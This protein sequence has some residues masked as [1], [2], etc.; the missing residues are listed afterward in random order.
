MFE[1]LFSAFFSLLVLGFGVLFSYLG[2]KIIGDEI[3]S[4]RK[5]IA[6][7]EWSSSA[8][9][10]ISSELHIAYGRRATYYPR[11]KY[12]Y[13]V[14][15]QNY[16]GERIAFAWRGVF[17]RQ[18]AE[19]VV[20][21]YPPRQMVKVFY[22]PRQPDDATLDRNFPWPIFEL[23]IGVLVVLCPGVTCAGMGISFIADTIRQIGLFPK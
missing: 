12:S 2:L 1:M 10:V 9:R 23:F 4:W 20:E 15:G 14:A 13:T 17:D 5:A 18:A 7:Q 11:A 6:S 22:D 19:K 8:G 21:R 16:T 3:Q